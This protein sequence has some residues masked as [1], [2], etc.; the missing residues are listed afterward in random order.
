LR[1]FVVVRH[2]ESQRNVERRVSGNPDV[3]VALTAKG[4]AEARA[5]AEQI[6]HVPFDVCFHTRF[7][8]T[9]RTAELAL[10]GRGVLTVEEPLFDDIRV[11]ELDGHTLEEYRTWK[12]AHTSADAFPGG[13]SLNDAARRY[14]EGYRTL[15]AREEQRILLV[16][17]EIPVR[18]ALN[19]VAGS[20]ELDAPIHDV[21]NATPYLFDEESL[22]SASDRLERLAAG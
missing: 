9:R 13:E 7:E 17:H 18:W 8:R 4:E 2:G 6:R 1:L 5:L 20:N 22:T 3:P 10:A 14:A 16:T 15:L 21:R 12:R 11:G 19:C